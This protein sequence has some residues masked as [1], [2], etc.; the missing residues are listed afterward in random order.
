MGRGRRPH[1]HQP[2]R[3][4]EWLASGAN[5]KPDG[6][7]VFSKP[8]TIDF[9]AEF[10]RK[11]K[12]E[13]K[14]TGV[15]FTGPEAIKGTLSPPKLDLA[16][17]TVETTNAEGTPLPP[18][19]RLSRRIKSLDEQREVYVMGYPARS[20][21]ESGKVLMKVFR[22]EYFVKRFAPGYVDDNPDAV[23]DDGHHR[24]FTHDAS[25]LG[26]NSGS[27]VVEFLIDG[28]AVVGLHFG[29]FSGDK[30]YAHAMA[31]VEQVL[32]QLGAKFQD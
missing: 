2:P 5:P 28:R 16:L 3:R 19:L 27:C 7:W 10:E 21:S 22:D 9:A 17:L 30:N 1:R 31:R 4:Q 18:P 12:N 25:T 20:T 29:G 6:T 13:F 32:S 26:G 8:V 23:E 11:R 15:A 14:V 24:V